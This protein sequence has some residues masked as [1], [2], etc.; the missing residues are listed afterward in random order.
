MLAELKDFLTINF[1][2]FF[3]NPAVY[4]DLEEVFFKNASKNRP[5]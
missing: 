2:E 4:K 5:G 1:S 3:R